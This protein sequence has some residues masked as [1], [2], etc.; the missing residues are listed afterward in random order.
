M[1]AAP[2]T[3]TDSVSEAWTMGSFAL[4]EPRMAETGPKSGVQDSFGAAKVGVGSD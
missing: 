4:I 3:S 2:K 1:V